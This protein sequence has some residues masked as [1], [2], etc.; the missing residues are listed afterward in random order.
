MIHVG[1]FHYS[2]VSPR[3]VRKRR[4]H[5][6]PILASQQRMHPTRQLKFIPVLHIAW[7][8]IIMVCTSYDGWRGLR[9]EFSGKIFRIDVG[10]EAFGERCLVRP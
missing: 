6:N 9:A 3:K 5:A 1:N 4:N 2:Y 8:R 10:Y 7:L